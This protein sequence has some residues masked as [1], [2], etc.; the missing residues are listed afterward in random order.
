MFG[1]PFI[2][3]EEALEKETAAIIIVARATN[4]S[5]IY[6][7]ISSFC[8]KENIPA[9]DILGNRQV[10]VSENEECALPEKYAKISSIDV[11]RKIR[12]ADVVSFDIFDTLLVR[13]VLYPPGCVFSDGESP[14]SKARKNL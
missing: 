7:R 13:K 4:V 8:E 1:K 9:Y 14:E 11:K 5:V 3:I 6:R 10:S 12:A 2:S